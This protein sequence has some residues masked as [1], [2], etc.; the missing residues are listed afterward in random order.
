MVEWVPPLLPLAQIKIGGW[1]MKLKM[2]E[3]SDGQM[4]NLGAQVVRLQFQ[5]TQCQE[6]LKIAIEALEFYAGTHPVRTNC[7]DGI[8]GCLVAHFVKLTN[9]DDGK[10]AIEALKALGKVGG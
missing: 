10:R 2:P 6:K 4:M 9:G 1:G 7:P 5:L 3:V 8:E